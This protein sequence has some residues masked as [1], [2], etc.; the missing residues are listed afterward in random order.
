MVIYFITT[1]VNFIFGGLIMPYDFYNEE[2]YNIDY[3]TLYQ[4]LLEDSIL[5]DYNVNKKYILS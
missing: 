3:E 2:I 4:L 5:F 1:S